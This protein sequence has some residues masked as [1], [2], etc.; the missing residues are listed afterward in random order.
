MTVYWDGEERPGMTVGDVM[1]VLIDEATL[2]D[3]GDWHLLQFDAD[4]GEP[5]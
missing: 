4:D 1:R 3:D 5:A 2:R